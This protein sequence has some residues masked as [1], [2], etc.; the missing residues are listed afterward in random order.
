[1]EYDVIVAGAGPAGNTVGYELSR[2]GF[3]VLILEKE[4]LP[5]DKLCAGGIPWRILK[6]L[7]LQD[8]QMVEDR[9]NKVEFTFRLKERFVLESF[10]P[11]IY[12][13]RRR[14]FDQVLVQ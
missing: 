3:S 9:I 2:R 13:V 7:D 6:L 12:T 4:E 8:G 14:R 5:G 11:L 10:G 1:M